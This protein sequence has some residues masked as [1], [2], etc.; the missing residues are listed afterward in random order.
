[1]EQGL[2]IIY[3]AMAIGVG[4]LSVSLSSVMAA[5]VAIGV[6][7]ASF[8]VM[9]FKIKT[10]KTKWLVMNSLITYLLIWIL[11]WTFLFNTS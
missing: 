4:F 10:K 7:A 1:M 8:A 3:A 11:T 2:N 9:K 6:Y 5:A